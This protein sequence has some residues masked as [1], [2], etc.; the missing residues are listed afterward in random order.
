MLISLQGDSVAAGR[1]TPMVH[2]VLLIIITIWSAI[3]KRHQYQYSASRTTLW[4]PGTWVVH[5]AVSAIMSFLLVQATAARIKAYWRC[6]TKSSTDT[7]PGLLSAS[8]TRFVFH[9]LANTTI[10]LVC[11]FP[12]GIP[13]GEVET[14]MLQCDLPQAPTFSPPFSSPQLCSGEEFGAAQP[15]RCNW[16]CAVAPAWRVN[17][18]FFP[19]KR[20]LGELGQ[21][22]K[23]AAAPESW[24]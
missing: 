3:A 18:Q 8:T 10:H 14:W 19:K 21:L 12:A 5:P 15:K 22:R 20:L 11:L 7:L 13:K 16:T 17:Q 6:T 9:P 4:C 2:W 24:H 1:D 23:A